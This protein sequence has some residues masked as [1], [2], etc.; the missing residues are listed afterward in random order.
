[1]I[2][3]GNLSDKPIELRFEVDPALPHTLV[4]DAMRLQQVLVNLGGNAIKFTSQGEVVLGV[5]VLERQADEVTLEASVRDTGI[6]I[7]PENHERIFSGFTQAEASTTRRFG[8]TGLGVA[9][10]QR[11]VALMG[12]EL[13][14]HS[15]LGQGSR[16][17]FQLRLPVADSEQALPADAARAVGQ[18]AA[19]VAPSVGGRLT[20][21]RLLVAEDNANNQQVARELLGDEGASVDIAPHG[22]AAVAAVAAASPPYDAVLMDLQMPEMDGYTATSRIRQDL[23]LHALP[24]VAM[25]ANAMASDRAACLAAGMNE[26]V[27]KPFDLDHLV[28]VLQRLT[29]R[30]VTAVAQPLPRPAGIECGAIELDAALRRLGGRRDVYRR[31]LANLVT[32]LGRWPGQWGA[33]AGAG[34]TDELRREAHALKGVAATLGAAHLSAQAAAAEHAFAGAPAAAASSLEALLAAMAETLPALRALAAQLQDDPPVAA[35]EGP[36]EPLDGLLGALEQQ[37]A[38]DDMDAQATLDRLRAMHGERLGKRLA[39]LEQ[40]IGQ[41]DFSQALALCRALREDCQT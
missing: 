11:L 38:Q 19:A 36:L 15:A 28:G 12:G 30:T 16:F 24:I 25:T 21:L 29:G 7:A 18:P 23:G 41:L 13:R 2:L 9:L 34:R 35:A 6:G 1:M 22:A 31:L 10:C 26:H 40:A 4:G 3:A 14:L 37:L 17:W 33:L 8:G 20:G 27:G 32:D 5:A 39:P